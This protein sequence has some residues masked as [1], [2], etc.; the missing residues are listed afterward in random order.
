MNIIHSKITH[1]KPQTVASIKKSYDIFQKKSRDVLELRNIINNLNTTYGI[2]GTVAPMYKEND[3]NNKKLY[4]G[5][6]AQ[7]N[8]PIPIYMLIKLGVIWEN[9][10]VV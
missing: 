4:N 8:T 6:A 1:L 5:G 7:F 2:S 3:I 9:N 10:K